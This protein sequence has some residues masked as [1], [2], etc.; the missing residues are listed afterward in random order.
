MLSRVVHYSK[1]PLYKVSSTFA[2]LVYFLKTIISP[3]MYT[4]N[5]LIP[6]QGKASLPRLFYYSKARPLSKAAPTFLRLFLS[7]GFSNIQRSVYLFRNSFFK[8]YPLSQGS[9]T[10]LRLVY[11]PSAHLLLLSQSSYNLLKSVYTI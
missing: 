2:R 11:N 4:P 3:R 7:R 6:S 1:T 5:V 10:T 8:V 9:S